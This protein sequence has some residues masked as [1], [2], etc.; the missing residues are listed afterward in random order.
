MSVDNP[1]LADWLGRYGSWLVELCLI[2]VAMFWMVGAHNRLQRLR[3]EVNAAWQ[4]I[5]QLLLR[6][7]GV[8]GPMLAALRQAMPE[9]AASLSALDHAHEQ[10]RLAAV[11]ARAQPTRQRRLAAWMAA[12]REMVSPLAR[13]DGLL[14]QRSELADHPLVAPGR[15]HLTE[16]AEQMQFARQRFNAAAQAYN[17]AVN[18]IPTRLVARLFGMR[19]VSTF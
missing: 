13:L 10:Q 17:E 11:A 1:L 3:Q 15:Q 8:L 16:V 9:E 12:E 19:A 7:A 2:L 6:R 18:E 4:P 5:D 14:S